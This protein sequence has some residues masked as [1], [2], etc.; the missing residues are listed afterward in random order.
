VSATALSDERRRFRRL[1][2]KDDLRALPYL[3]PWLV[4]IALFFLY[5]L[6]AT[7]YYS[8]TH[9]D[10]INPA[11]FVGLDN[12]KYVLREDPLFYSALRN[13]LWLVAVMVP[14]RTIVGLG[15]G[16]LVT[17]VKRG[18][19]GLRTLLYLPY[20]APPV[21]A[22]LAFVFL[23]NPGTG[24]V[25]QVL[26]AVGV[27]APNWFSDPST[28]K[29][30]LTML[31][32]WGVGDLMIIFLA[33]LLDVPREQYEAATLDG[34][35]PFQQFRFVTLPT[36]R[37]IILFAVV[38]GV[39]GTMQYYTQAIVAGK[40]AS[41]TSVGPGTTFDPGYPDGST[42]TLPQL[43]YSMGFQNF[44]TGAAS[45]VAVILVAISLGFTLLLLRR[46][47]GFLSAEELP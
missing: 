26:Q 34:A 44:D 19:G 7:V 27:H 6:G 21:A 29:P 40:V 25:N 45:V 5:P 37:P 24:P 23:L 10:Q 38:T 12:W 18:A 35:G 36:I 22:T 1:R 39:I 8:F 43:I 9:Y 16:L 15:L 32:V 42:L 31:A 14:A 47:A 3:A 30:A 4:G 17:R 41:G 46:G 33:S 2:R 28:A 11:T 20:L 13:T